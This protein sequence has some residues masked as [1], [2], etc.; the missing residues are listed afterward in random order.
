MSNELVNTKDFLENVRANVKEQFANLIPEERLDAFIK[1][2]VDEFVEKD[3]KELVKKELQI[4][5]EGFIKAH[6][7]QYTAFQ[8][9][10][11]RQVVNDALKK[12]LTDVAANM[13]L[14]TIGDQIAYTI[15]NVQNSIRR[16]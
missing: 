5:C 12:L 10:G 8:W 7:A 15:Q 2:T 16:Y 13:F 3:L 6:M 1:S 9:E 14:N 4:Y 11:G